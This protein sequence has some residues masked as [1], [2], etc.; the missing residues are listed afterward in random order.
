LR[1]NS[2]ALASGCFSTDFI[3]SIMELKI[4]YPL[5]WISSNRYINLPF[6]LVDARLDLLPAYFDFT[7]KVSAFRSTVGVGLRSG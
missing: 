5:L 3:A 2:T 1:R 6:Y 4:N 7:G